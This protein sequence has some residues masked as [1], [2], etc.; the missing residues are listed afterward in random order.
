[1][2]VYPSHPLQPQPPFGDDGGVASPIR[3]AAPGSVDIRTDRQ[4][5]CTTTPS[6]PWR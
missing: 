5:I 3:H 6:G 2:S 4:V 1:M